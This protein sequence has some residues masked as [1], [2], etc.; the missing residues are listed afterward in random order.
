MQP[1][2]IGILGEIR[3][4]KDTVAQLITHQLKEIN[5]YIP[6]EHFAFSGG[7]HT[8]INLTMPELY[9]QGKPRKALQLLGQAFRQV[10]ADVWIDYLFNHQYFKWAKRSGYNILITDVRQPN[11]VI[12]LQEQGFK[13]IKVTASPE[14]R[15]ERAKDQGDNF[16]ESMFT[17]ETE[18]VIQSCKYDYLIDNSYSIDVLEDTVKEVLK[19]VIADE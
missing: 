16:D 9:E 6:T 14:V 13:I 1:V 5:P 15:L 4:G 3:A 8:V 18:L 7:I 10:K 2:K 11:E 19:E 17:H 12:R